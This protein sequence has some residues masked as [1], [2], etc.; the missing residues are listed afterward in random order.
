MPGALIRA[1]SITAA[2]LMASSC[3]SLQ[4][5]EGGGQTVTP[6][7][8]P[9][10]PADVALP[11]GYAI[12]LFASGLTFPTSIA[13]DDAG[14]IY[15]TEAGY[16][17]G[18]VFTTPRL[19]ELRA[20]RAPRVV[21]SGDNGPWTGVA[22]HGGAFYV[23]EGGTGRGGR[24]VRIG[25]DGSITSLVTGL[26]TLGD[27]HTNGPLIGPDG[28][29]YFSTGTATNSA[30]VG[31]DNAQ[32]GWLKR[33]PE[34]HDVPC[35]DVVLTGVNF[36]TPN[37]LTP[38]EDDSASTGAFSKFGDKTAA[39]QVIT[40][41]VPCSGAVMRVALDGGPIE[42]VAW[43]FRNP[44]GLAFGPDRKLYVTDNGYD[45]R[46][47]RPVFG[48]GDVLWQVQP[49]T[50]FGWPDFSEAHPIFEDPV[51]GDH[52]R[53]PGKDTPPRLLARHP[54]RP[55]PATAIFPVHA[56]A[57]GLD[58]S[59]SAAFG[60]PGQAFVALFG[61]EAPATGKTLEPVGF[62]V[63]RVDVTNGVI[64]DFA[65]N[66]AKHKGPASKSGGSGLER[67]VAVRFDPS[68]RSLYVVDFGV[69]THHERAEP[70][71]GTGTVWRITRSEATP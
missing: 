47:S 16:S 65:V 51:W 71:Q 41:K 31:E 33:H 21:A 11:P 70:V 53:V 28:K 58:F 57:D 6:A 4:S 39:Q 38:D 48:A 7:S 14:N 67:P 64:A 59:R 52:Y 9:L 68:G 29:L 26:P 54:S 3:F 20:G 36:K 17:Y 5:S 42:L 23:A 24:I 56:S 10:R 55:P 50:W 60:Y 69:L 22:F 35:Q 66:R 13:F 32:F 49:G 40:G 27:H 2:A 30:V 61:D 8:R 45:D 43:G 46:G 19:L 62:K 25:R 1:G 12:E 63:V 15:V 34:F 44:F 18:E 37:P